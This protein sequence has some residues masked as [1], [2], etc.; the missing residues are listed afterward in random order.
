MVSIRLS[1][2]ATPTTIS[3][4]FFPFHLRKRQYA[5]HEL[6]GLQL[7]EIS[8]LGDFG[9]WGLRYSGAHGWGYIMG[10]QW[11]LKFTTPEGQKLV[12]SI[13]KDEALRHFLKQH[14]LLPN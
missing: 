1:F 14:G 12:I 2:S 5:W 8:A 3:W 7:I 13:R 4:Q 9:G 6:K 11:G 10:G